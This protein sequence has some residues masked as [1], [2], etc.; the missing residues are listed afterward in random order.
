MVLAAGDVV[1]F[2]EILVRLEYGEPF[3]LFLIFVF[4][5]MLSLLLYV[6]FRDNYFR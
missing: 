2:G 5:S 6:D 1:D 3:P 4:T